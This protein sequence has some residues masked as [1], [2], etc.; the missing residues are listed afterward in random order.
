MQQQSHHRKSLPVNIQEREVYMPVIQVRALEIIVS[1][2]PRI[3]DSLKRIADAL[4][5]TKAKEQS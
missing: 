1:Y 3:S 4:E 2:L 5:I